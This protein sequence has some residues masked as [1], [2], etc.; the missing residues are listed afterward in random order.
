MCF[1][2]KVKQYCDRKVIQADQA[3][4]PAEPKSK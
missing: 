2:K 4:Q 3:S 1:V